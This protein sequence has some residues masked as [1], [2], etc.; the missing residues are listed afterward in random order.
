MPVEEPD[1]HNDPAAQ[2]TRLLAH[3]APEERELVENAYVPAQRAYE[4]HSRRIT[5][6]ESR[7]PF[8]VHPLRVARI[9]AEEWGKKDGQTLAT[10]LLHDAIRYGPPHIAPDI[11]R[12]VGKRIEKAVWTLTKPRL[13]EPCPEDTRAA[14]DARYF[15]SL[16]HAPK[17]I[18][19]IK[20]ADR[21]DNLRDARLWGNQ[22]FWARFSS[23]T[24]GWHLVLARET[25]PIAEVALFAAL[26]EGERQL[27]GRV[28]VWADG[29]IIDPGA[30]ALIPEH[31]ARHNRVIGLAARG[32]TLQVG[33][34][35]LEDAQAIRAVAVT[36]QK[37]IEP[38]AV[39]AE[40]IDDALAAGLYGRLHAA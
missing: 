10:A 34:C 5:G 25:A 3:V 12:A 15:S 38:V 17:W 31:V 4:G 29:R 36:T 33:L 11:E 26:V 7:I 2:W 19:L 13:P 16:R 1:T 9:L 23:E 37:Q 40:A 8:I 32:E 39:T 21:V 28:P 22:E 14:R 18:R 6:R 24:I 30:A 20:C 27:R 35:D